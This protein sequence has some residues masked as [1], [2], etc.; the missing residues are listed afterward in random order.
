MRGS[1][2]P[3]PIR[4]HGVVLNW[5]STGTTLPYHKTYNTDHRYQCDVFPTIINIRVECC[6]LSLGMLHLQNYEIKVTFSLYSP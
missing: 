5:L 3:P 2:H 4:L 1:T 6:I